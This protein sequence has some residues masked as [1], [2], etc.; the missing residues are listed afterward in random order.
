MGGMTVCLYVFPSL[1]KEYR[2]VHPAVDVRVTP[3][4]VTRLMRKFRAG[5]ADLAL[6]TLPIHDPNLV[7]VPVMQEELLLVTSAHHSLA[8]RKYVSAKD[9]QR[10]PFVLFE[11]GSSTRRALDQFFLQEHIEPRIVTETENVE[12]IK[13]MVRVGLGISIVPYQAVAREVRA[14]QLA[15]ARIEGHLLVRETGWV[16]A[17]TSRVPRM[18]EEMMKTLTRILPKLRL[19]PRGGVPASSGNGHG[20]GTGHAGAPA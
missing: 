1:I 20:S 15:C 6:L 13:A 5:S 8:R 9:L 11:A 10:Q 16:Y 19:A 12:I 17:R 14:G 18:V 3:G 7:T 4:T 2:R